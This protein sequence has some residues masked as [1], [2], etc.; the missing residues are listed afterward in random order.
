MGVLFIIGNGFDLNCGMKTK[1]TD[2][3]PEYVKCDSKSENIIKFKIEI[4][5][6]YDSWSDFEIAMGKYAKKLK[7]ESEF[8]ECIRDFSD[9]M[10]NHLSNQEAKILKIL[11]DENIG[12]ACKEEFGNSLDNFY[13]EITPRVTRKVQSYRFY[14]DYSAVT[15][16]YTRIFDWFFQNYMWSHRIAVDVTHVHGTLMEGPILGVDNINQIDSDYQLSY[17][18]QRAFIKP[19]FNNEYDDFRVEDV[20]RKIASA[21]FICLF[22]ISLGDS[23]LMW[24]EEI[25]KWLKA[26]SNRNL[27]IFD[28]RY[29]QKKVLSATEKLDIMDDAKDEVLQKLVVGQDESLREQIFVH[30]GKNIF[31]IGSVLSK[32]IEDIEKNKELQKQTNEM[33]SFR[34]IFNI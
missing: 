34:K 21:D 30:V 4:G 2:V 12:N 16:N 26:N 32:T 24:K 9:F 31:N 10:I 7:S 13:T 20:K 8:V 18:G 27:F 5:N 17:R 3:Y 22:G 6:D 25:V 29:S 23:D 1:Y 14:R 11:E 19:I 28:Y 33:E 15:F